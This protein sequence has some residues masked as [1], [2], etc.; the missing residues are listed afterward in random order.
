MPSN[1]VSIFLA[2]AHPD[3]AYF[4][5]A[6]LAEGLARARARVRGALDGDLE[7]RAGPRQ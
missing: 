4:K 2:D 7:L 5:A 6:T 1:A 3:R